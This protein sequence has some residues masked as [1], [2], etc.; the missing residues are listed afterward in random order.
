M[1]YIF[2]LISAI[3]LYFL[4]KSY[5]DNHLHGNITYGQSVGAGIIIFL[6]YSIIAAIFTYILYK[7]I[8]PG[9]TDKMMAFTEDTIR[10]Q[11]RVPE[12]SMETVM[13]FQRKMMQPGILAI[14]TIFFTMIF[15]TIVTLLV[16]IFTRKEGNPLID[17]LDTP[18]N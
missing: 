9:L 10:R 3:L 8:D 17:T 11:G 16:S 7:V 2:L 4:I 1:Q 13:A 18:A 6:Y 15:G 12:S 14:G 5:R